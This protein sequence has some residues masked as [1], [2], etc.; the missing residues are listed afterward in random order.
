MQGDKHGR[1][2]APIR[3]AWNDRGFNKTRSGNGWPAKMDEPSVGG[4]CLLLLESLAVEFQRTA[5]FGHSAHK[6]VRGAVR[7][8]GIDLDGHDDLCAHLTC[9]MGNHFV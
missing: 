6:L 9:Q 5:I 7:K 1:A 2:S 8:P 3:G 4:D